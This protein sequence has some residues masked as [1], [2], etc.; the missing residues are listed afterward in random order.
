M[1]LQAL[2][3]KAKQTQQPTC[4]GFLSPPI[5]RLENTIISPSRI[6]PCEE[7]EDKRTGVG[8]RRV[9]VDIEHR[10]GVLSLFY[11]PLIQDDRYEVHTRVL[12]EGQTGSVGEKTDVHC[13]NIA[14]HIPV[15]INN[16]QARQTFLVHQTESVGQ[17]ALGTDMTISDEHDQGYIIK[18]T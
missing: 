4:G 1:V 17:R 13:R 15:T 8:K 14:D 9:R 10:E 5:L 16:S 2:M 18:Q 11:T 12:Q 6:L 3:V 7:C